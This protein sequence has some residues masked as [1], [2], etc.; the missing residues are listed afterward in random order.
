MR[1]IEWVAARLKE[2][3]AW[4]VS[5]S[6]ARGG[7]VCPLGNLKEWVGQTGD[8]R[9]GQHGS[10]QY[11][12][13]E[14]LSTDRAVASLPEE[15]R[16]TVILAY[17]FEGGNDLVCVR[18]GITGRTLHNRLCHAD[19]RIQEWFTQRKINGSECKNNFAT[20]F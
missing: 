7:Y 12:D 15:L 8:V 13:T 11:E 16:R 10:L 3:A 14:V 17:C 20:F 6:V 1:R 19:V 2:W 18:L 9:P 4:R 5:G